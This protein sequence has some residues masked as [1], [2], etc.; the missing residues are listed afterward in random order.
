MKL[1]IWTKRK[2]KDSKF[3]NKQ[4]AKEAETIKNLTERLDDLNETSKY[5]MKCLS[6]NEPISNKILKK[7]VDEKSDEH[8][9]EFKKYLG[10][11]L[12]TFNI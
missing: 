4:L 1:K 11:L 6:G 8:E 5:V 2:Q 10:E 7:E 12:D 3:S 9:D